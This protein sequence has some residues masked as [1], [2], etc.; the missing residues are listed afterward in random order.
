M[1]GISTIITSMKSIITMWPGRGSADP[2]ELDPDSSVHVITTP[3][4]VVDWV[5]NII[6]RSIRPALMGL[7]VYMF[8]WFALDPERAKAWIAVVKDVP[9]QMWNIIFTLVISVG[10]SKA[11]R[12]AKA[13]ASQSKILVSSDVKSET[14]TEDEKKS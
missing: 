13:P 8:V 3:T 12:D 4:T 10:V 5:F 7:I 6:S 11:I 2:I 14:V 1:F 9:E